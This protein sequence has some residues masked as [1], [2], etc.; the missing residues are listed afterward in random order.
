MYLTSVLLGIPGVKSPDVVIDVSLG[1]VRYLSCKN[2]LKGSHTPSPL[3]AF[4]I[5]SFDVS[6]KDLE[7]Q[8]TA[9]F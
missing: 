3:T 1:H 5:T 8:G 9:S 7:G 6:L 2:L 4:N